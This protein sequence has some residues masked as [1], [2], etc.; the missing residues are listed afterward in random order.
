VSGVRLLLGAPLVVFRAG[1]AEPALLM[2]GFFLIALPAAALSAA[3]RP[4]PGAPRP[5]ALEATLAVVAAS[6]AILLAFA[7]TGWLASPV[8]A[9][10]LTPLPSSISGG[11]QWLRTIDLAAGA[12]TLA[13]TAV[14]LW[15]VLVYRLPIPAWLRAL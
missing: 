6:A 1:Q 9:A 14:I 3:R 15:A 11:G 5:G 13:L 7:V 4:R 10:W 2:I 12:D 8:R